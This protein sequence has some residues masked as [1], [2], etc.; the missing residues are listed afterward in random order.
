MN[1][2]KEDFNLYK[3]KLFDKN[4]YVVF[5][6]DEKDIGTKNKYDYFYDK[7]A[8]GEIVY[9]IVTKGTKTFEDV[10]VARDVAEIYIPMIKGGIFNGSSEIYYDIT[11]KREAFNKLINKISIIYAS[12]SLLF[13][14]LLF[15]LLY[16]AS[17]LNLKEKAKDIQI[18]QQSKMAS[19]GEMIGNIAHQWRQP[20][21]AISSAAS[22]LVI[23]KEMG[24]L[25][26]ST[27]KSSTDRIID[28]TQ[29]LSK[30]IDDFRNFFHVDKEQKEY[31]MGE[32]LTSTLSIVKTT[33]ENVRVKTV[34]DVE[35][36]QL[37]GLEN[38]LKQALL[39][40]ILNAKD[41]LGT[42]DLDD[43]YL[44]I[45]GEKKE[46]TYILSI[47]DNA[48]GVPS[49][50]IDKIFEPYFTTKHQS[51]GTGIGLFMTSEIVQKHIGGE[52]SVENDE[53]EYEMKQYIGAKFVITLPIKK[54][55]NEI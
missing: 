37:F 40:I 51:Q 15:I 52:I 41:A 22:G 3:I 46:T 5:S 1:K 17:K 32:L 4:G 36:V 25:E 18:F 23:H 31:M 7:V 50:I 42:I 10:V 2:L 19:M 47:I 27:F 24:I 35:D 28:S 30:T 13:L 8:K 33:L 53:Y 14:I 44:F 16:N 48:G 38:E 11:D 12:F 34:L 49:D 43:K 21:S 9:K 45:S 20:L 6:T 55:E 26:D 29:Y 54:D 39:N